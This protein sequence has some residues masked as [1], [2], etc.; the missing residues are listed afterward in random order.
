MRSMRPTRCTSLLLIFSIFLVY[1]Q[2][3]VASIHP[4]IILYAK[5]LSERQQPVQNL[6]ENTNL[7][8]SNFIYASLTKKMTKNLVL[9]S[10]V[11]YFSKKLFYFKTFSFASRTRCKCLSN[12][13]SCILFSELKILEKNLDPCILRTDFG[14]CFQA[15]ILDPL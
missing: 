7:I 14:K 10:G 8:F 4:K 2:T 9:R 12:Q 1:F 11:A 6:M 5:T 13:F 3:T 15:Q